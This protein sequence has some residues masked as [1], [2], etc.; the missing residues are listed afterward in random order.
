MMGYQLVDIYDNVVEDHVAELIHTQIKGCAWKFDYHSNKQKPNKYL[1][2]VRGV[3]QLLT[4]R[5]ASAIA[6]CPGPLSEHEGWR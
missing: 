1:L 2:K 4:R 5:S 3:V 6:P